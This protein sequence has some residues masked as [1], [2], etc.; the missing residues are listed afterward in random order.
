MQ[1]QG[2]TSNM[3]KGL[4]EMEKVKDVETG[5]KGRG[6][7]ETETEGEREGEREKETL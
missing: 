2:Y 5:V 6:K 1:I 7:G 3:L 4:A